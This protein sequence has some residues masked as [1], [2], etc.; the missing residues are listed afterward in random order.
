M[1]TDFKPL[2]SNDKSVNVE[3]APFMPSDRSVSPPVLEHTGTC[4]RRWMAIQTPVADT[5]AVEWG[6]LNEQTWRPWYQSL[7]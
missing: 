5:E 6:H 3:S 7:S 2:F 4:A 1:R